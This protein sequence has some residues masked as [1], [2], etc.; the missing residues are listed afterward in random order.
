MEL[1][2]KQEKIAIGVGVLL[3]VAVGYYVFVRK[4]P[5]AAAATPYYPPPPTPTTPKPP[6][7]GP[8]PPGP[9]SLP[10]MIVPGSGDVIPEGAP[11]LQPIYTY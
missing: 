7:L 2:K 8:A 4:A 3:A 10:P 5:T 9:N 6:Q 11:G 1:T